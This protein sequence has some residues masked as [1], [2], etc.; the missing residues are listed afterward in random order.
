MR[1]GTI[2][3]AIFEVKA[4]IQDFRMQSIGGLVTALDL[5]ERAIIP[6]LLN[7]SESWT[8]ISQTAIK[9]LEE[10]Q[11]MFLRVILDT[12]FS[13]PKPAL[14]WETGMAPME[15][16]IMVKK[17]KFI[18]SIKH[19]DDSV[20][21]K[22]ILQEQIRLQLPG[23]AKEC[24]EICHRFGLDNITKNEVPVKEWKMKVDRASR[25]QAEVE[26]KEEIERKDYSK[27]KY[28]KNEEFKMK[29]YIKM[30]SIEN[31]RTMFRIRSS[32]VDVKFNYKN[33]KRYSHELWK[34]EGCKSAIETQSHII[35]CPAFA[36]FKGKKDRTLTLTW[37]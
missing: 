2:I 33:D 35:N 31:A 10:L 16:R 3:A 26:M 20:L 6:T 36:N 24:V 28:V 34:C 14:K 13:T 21:S 11:N 22:E 8:E 37:I 29:E 4:I 17:L 9:K 25:T 30:K 27:M 23:L 1:S 18:N 15:N 19:Q 7:N 5:W 32:M 12:P